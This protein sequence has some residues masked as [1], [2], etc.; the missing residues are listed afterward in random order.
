LPKYFLFSLCLFASFTAQAAKA[1][2]PKAAK[3]ETQTEEEKID[4][5]LAELEALIRDSRLAPRKDGQPAQ[6][7]DFREDLE[8]SSTLKTVP[9]AAPQ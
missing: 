3:A 8:I 7:E 1:P 2:A 6:L 9:Q 4:A 5:S